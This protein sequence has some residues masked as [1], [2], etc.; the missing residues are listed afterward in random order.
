M[1]RPITQT[2]PDPG[3]LENNQ[4]VTHASIENVSAAHISFLQR[5]HVY[6]MDT[7][8]L[9]SKCRFRWRAVVA[10]YSHLSQGYLTLSFLLSICS[11]SSDNAVSAY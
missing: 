1:T 2:A 5:F 9:L 8:R 6:N 10:T 4:R 7:L 11:Y 3:D